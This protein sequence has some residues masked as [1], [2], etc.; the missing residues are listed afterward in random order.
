MFE[1]I[2]KIVDAFDNVAQRLENAAHWLHEAAK[3]F[4]EAMDR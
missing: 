3:K 4:S 2:I 1:K